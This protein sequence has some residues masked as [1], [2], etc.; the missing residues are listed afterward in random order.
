MSSALF[1]FPK[2]LFDDTLRAYTRMIASR[3]IQ[4]CKS[5]HSV[6]S[7]EEILKG[8]AQSM[9][10]VQSPRDIR[11]GDR[12]D[13]GTSGHVVIMLCKLWPK[14]T[15]LRPPGVPT[16]LNNGWNICS[17]VWGV[18]RPKDSMTRHHVSTVLG[19]MVEYENDNGE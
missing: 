16:R 15:L 17:V 18:Q 7:D 10:T 11:W 19:K 3:E 1:L 13:K 9:T 8:S 5:P 4:S 6:P 2:H 12:D 14:E